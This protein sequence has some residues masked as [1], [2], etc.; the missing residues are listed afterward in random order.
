LNLLHPNRTGPTAPRLLYA[1][2]LAALAGCTRPETPRIRADAPPAFFQERDWPDALFL[3]KSVAEIRQMMKGAIETPVTLRARS[4]LIDAVVRELSQQTGLGIGITPGVY[5][6]NDGRRLELD[7]RNLPARYALEWLARLSRSYYAAE[8]PQTVFLT[9]DRNWASQDRLQMR[10]YSV[11]TFHRL[12][13]PVPARYDPSYEAQQLVF[14]LRY[15]LRHV[16]AGHEDASLILDHTGSR[17]TARLPPRGH[18]KLARILEELK[19]P[20]RYDPAIAEDPVAATRKRLDAPVTCTFPKQDLRRIVRDL[21]AQAKV[22][23]GLDYRRV[24]EDR[25]AVALNLGRTTL[26][27]ALRAL[28]DAAGLGEI[29]PETGRRIWILGPGQEPSFFRETGELPWDRAVVRSYYVRRLADQ[30]GV[31]LLFQTLRK[32]VT[33]GLWDADL[34]VA[35]YHHPTGRLVVIHDPAAQRAVAL[36]IRRMMGVTRPDLRPPEE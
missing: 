28:R 3:G 15:C 31:P 2:A 19:G 5:A 22:H 14:A 25:R 6:A 1:L 21:A 20:R 33:P 29:V 7:V 35:F 24:P 34:P 17:L 18:A 26:G 4:A 10:S 30:F 32:E 16:M 9:R 13:R 36:S 23:V 8:D 11:G 12:G 27:A